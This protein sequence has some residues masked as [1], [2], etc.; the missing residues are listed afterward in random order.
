[1][2][3]TDSGVPRCMDRGSAG[4][5]AAPPW[6][7]E[8]W[9]GRSRAGVHSRLVRSSSEVRLGAAA[10]SRGGSM[11]HV[12]LRTSRSSGAPP[13]AQA[14]RSRAARGASDALSRRARFS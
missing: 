7:R 4:V 3:P 11:R 9:V 1:M 2:R 10:W 12:V 8:R 6:M 13:E 14:R 5:A